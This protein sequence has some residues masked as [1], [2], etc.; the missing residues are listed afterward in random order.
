MIMPINPKSK[1]SV[2]AL[3]VMS[4]VYQA[5]PRPVMAATPSER[6]RPSKSQSATTN[7]S[8][9]SLPNPKPQPTSAN[10]NPN[11]LGPVITASMTDAFID[12]NASNRADPGSV[13]TYTAVISNT[14]G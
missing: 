6:T 5:V 7:G 4:L 12:N 3:L 2:V 11:V 14:G 8:E 9:L 10:P 13:I 1:L